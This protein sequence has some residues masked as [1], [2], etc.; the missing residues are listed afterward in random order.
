MSAASDPATI[1]GPSANKPTLL[2]VLVIVALVIG[3][4]LAFLIE[5]LD[6]R[7]R[8]VGEVENL[9]QL[10]IYGTIPPAPAPGKERSHS[11]S[12]A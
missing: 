11:S 9:L 1:P 12:A 8:N 3:L 7:I 6:D 5:Y 10:P 4:A 2:L